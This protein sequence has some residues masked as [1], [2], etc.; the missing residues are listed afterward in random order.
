MTVAKVSQENS[1]SLPSYVQSDEPQ[2]Q[3]KG[4]KH[5]LLQDAVV[6]DI[7]ISTQ[8]NMCFLT[9]PNMAGKSTFLKSLAIA[10][11]LAHVGFPVPAQQ[12][13]TSV[14][15][16]IMTTI[17][18]SDNLGFGYSHFYSE[19]NRIKEAAIT[20]AKGNRML[21]IF[22]EL[23]RG[24]N[25]K[26]AFEAS[27]EIIKAFAK[28]PSCTFFMSTHIVEIAEKIHDKN[29]IMLKYFDSDL[30]GNDL[31]YS[32]KLKD[33]VSDERLGMFIIHKEGIFDLLK[34]V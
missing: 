19:V 10:I 24:T 20:L 31:I 8:H 5:P 33:G 12:L 11:Y 18:L 22:D 23:F 9:G 15:S 32:Y 30:V 1:F 7:E 29:N 26:D 6:N 34:S 14:Y 25:V 2:F 16:G 3:I 4:L 21:I 17:N 28:I 27:T 13:K